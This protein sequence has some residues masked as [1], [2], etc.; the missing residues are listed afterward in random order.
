[1]EEKSTNI[2]L[3]NVKYKLRNSMCIRNYMQICYPRP[4]GI[5]VL[6]ESTFDSLDDSEYRI[7]EEYLEKNGIKIK[8]INLGVFS[9]I[10]FPRQAKSRVLMRYS[11]L[12]NTLKLRNKGRSYTT[13]KKLEEVCRELKLDDVI[14]EAMLDTIIDLG[15]MVRRFE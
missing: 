13:F 14:K 5:K 4:H 8:K 6:M 10:D 7:I 12:I 3:M 11:Y 2:D 1:V 15:I 9:G